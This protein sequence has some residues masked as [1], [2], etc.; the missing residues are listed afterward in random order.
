MKI[1]Y[2]ITKSEIGGAQTHVSQLVDFF[3][4]NNHEVSVMSLPGGW[5]ESEV[6][7]VGA[8]FYSNIYFSNNFNPFRFFRAIKTIQDFVREFKPD[9]V[10]CHSTAAGFLGR[11][12][13]RNSI[14]T[15]YTAHGWSFEPGTPFWRRIPAI[16]MEKY[17]T[18][19]CKKIICV[20][21]YTRDVGVKYRVANKA[22]FTVVYN[23]IE[24]IEILPKVKNETIKIIFIGRLSKQKDPELLVRAAASLPNDLIKKIEVRII[25]GG[26]KADRL[27]KLVDDNKNLVTFCLDNISRDRAME[28]LKNSDIFVLSTNWEGFPYSILEAMSV[29]LPVVATDVGGIN[30]AVDQS[31][32]F[33]IKCGDV[34]GL[35]KA[36]TKLIMDK[37]LRETMGGNAQ[38][39]VENKFSLE[40]MLSQTEKIY[41]EIL[42]K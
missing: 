7:K 42:E 15:I 6:G 19:F 34:E 1:L 24:K 5:L 25:G 33:L 3:V 2:L 30:E 16:V 26:P 37:N 29:G 17:A 8:K 20:S 13:I 21:N 23:G 12:A 28:M 35:Q 4:H 10:A 39:I 11:V 38:K 22:K 32:G 31:C 40:K 27:L 14:P 36:L 41:N 18:I 9:I